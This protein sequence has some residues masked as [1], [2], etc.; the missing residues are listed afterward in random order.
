MVMLQERARRP[1]E[2]HSSLVE[3]LLEVLKKLVVAKRGL[4]AIIVHVG[5][6]RVPKSAVFPVG[7]KQNRYMNKVT[8]FSSRRIPPEGSHSN[9]KSTQHTSKCESLAGT[10]CPQLANR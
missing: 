2:V 8:R 1:I 6:E 7:A 9:P 10:V 4:V 5:E 3:C